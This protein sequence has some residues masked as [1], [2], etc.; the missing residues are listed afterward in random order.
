VGFGPASARRQEPH[1]RDDQGAAL[2][3]FALVLPL[4]VLIL[5]GLI[6]FGFV[7]HGYNTL[8]NGVQAGARQASENTF[9]YSGTTSCGGSDPTSMMVCSV[10]S[11]IGSVFGVT[12]GSLQVGISITGASEHFQSGGQDVTVCASA[13]LNSTSGLLYKTFI[14]RTM[15]SSSTVFLAQAPSFGTFGQGSSVTYGG[16]VVNGRNC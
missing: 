11:D 8:R 2:V 9:N 14:N 3:E 5:F 16:T 1:P 6:D 13:A 15:S 7:F 4:T 12:P 10:V